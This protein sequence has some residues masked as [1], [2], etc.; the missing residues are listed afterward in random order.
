MLNPSFR[1]KNSLFLGSSTT[2]TASEGKIV[3]KIK[4]GGRMMKKRGKRFP[5]HAIYSQQTDR[6]LRFML[7]DIGN[8]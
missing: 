5:L 7:G 4:E 3:A 8:K 1:K 6:E 2:I